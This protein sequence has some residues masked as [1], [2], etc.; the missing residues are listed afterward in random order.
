MNLIF[1]NKK[2]S[3]LL[4][5]LPKNEIKFEDEMDNYNFTVAQSLKLKKIMGYGSHRV[6]ESG[7]TISDLCVYGLNY[8]FDQKLLKKEDIDA[9]VLV[10]Q[11]PDYILP[12]TSNVIQGK[13]GLKKDMIC[14]DINQGCAGYEIGL[15]QSFMLLD[16][17]DINK[18]VL[19]NAD[20]LS[21]KVS[22]RDRSNNP[23]IGDAASVTILEKSEKDQ[24]I[25]ANIKMD[26]TA[27]DTVI[28]PAGGFKTPSSP[29]TA[30]M[31]EDAEGNFRSLDQLCANGDKIFNFVQREVPPM[32]ES[33][34]EKACITKNDV[35]YFMFHQPNKFTLTK[36]AD[37]LQVPH[38]KLPSNILEFFGNSNG[39]SVPTSISFNLGD[40]LTKESLLICLAGF[41]VGLTW[42]SLLLRMEYLSFNEIIYF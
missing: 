11:S 40:R 37:K 13:L 26:G 2:I 4:T 32:I 36:L 35:D 25:Y 17:P 10:T 31:T 28:I 24:T 22:K 12:P 39:V 27:F 3:G 20:V 15:F 7:V 8:L 16:Q 5:V 19:L 34:L 33:L 18:V 23:L 9:I 29:A 1:Q 41:G 38:E 42:A 21:Q 14:L 6:V 30:E